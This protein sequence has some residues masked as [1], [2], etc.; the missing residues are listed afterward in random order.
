MTTLEARGRQ[1]IAI[2]GDFTR[3]IWVGKGREVGQIIGKMC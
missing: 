2:L 3:H 1:N